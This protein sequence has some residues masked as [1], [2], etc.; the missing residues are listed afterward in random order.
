MARY[1]IIA[2]EASGDMHGA[3]LMKQLIKLDND[4][5][6][7]FWGG[8][9]M[10]LAGGHL[11]KHTKELAFMGFLEVLLNI[12]T[13]LRN[14]RYCKWDILEYK[15]DVLI[16]IDYPGFNLRIAEFASKKGIRVVYYISPQ[17]W[18][19]K[20]SRVKKIKKSVDKLLVI[21]PFEMDFYRGSGVNVEFPGHPLL[22][23]IV[24]KRKSG[25]FEGFRQKNSLPGKP[26]VALL[27]GSRTQEIS[28]ILNGMVSVASCF[29][30]YHFVVA[31]VSE[32][33]RSLYERVARLDNLS[34]VYDQT[35][36]LLANSHAAIVASGT[37]TLEAALFG[38]PQVVVYRANPVSYH[39]AKQL[40]NIEFISLVNLIMGRE[41]IRE[42]IQGDFT[43]EKLGR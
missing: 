33:D 17:V 36:A 25:S 32:Q 11:V 7:R 28:K 2:G 21:L 26:L 9:R 35:Y 15:P 22:D 31:A 27:P 43:T 12:R 39:I 38:V 18:A 37:A 3:N 13:I 41:V 19:W 34:V 8:D 5:D 30:E 40:V 6:F 4:H 1:Y 24:P 42:L 10:S 20:S 23:E 29:S 16:L 14:I